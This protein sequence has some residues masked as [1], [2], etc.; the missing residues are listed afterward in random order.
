MKED[1]KDSGRQ[2]SLIIQKCFDEFTKDF[3]KR[4]DLASY[5]T[6]DLKLLESADQFQEILKSK[7]K[8]EEVFNKISISNLGTICS[9]EKIGIEQEK[10]DF[11]QAFKPKR[12]YKV[13]FDED[14]NV[15]TSPLED[16]E[17]WD[18]KKGGLDKSKQ[19]IVINSGNTPMLSLF[20]ASTLEQKELDKCVATEAKILEK[21]LRKV[22]APTEKRQYLVT[23]NESDGDNNMFLIREHNSLEGSALRKYSTP[24]STEQA[25][26][27]YGPLIFAEEG[28]PLPDK[29]IKDNLSKAV[30][31]NPSF[32]SLSANCHTIELIKIMRDSKVGEEVIKESI[33]SMHR[34]DAPNMVKIQTSEENYPGQNSV[35]FQAPND[36][37]AIAF[38]ATLPDKY[39]EQSQ[40]KDSNVLVV[41]TP[42]PNEVWN[43]A[44]RIK[45][46]KTGLTREPLKEELDRE[47]ELTKSL[48]KIKTL[49]EI[50]AL[51]EKNKFRKAFK[52]VIAQKEAKETVESR[53]QNTLKDLGLDG[54]RYTDPNK[55]N[56]P[57]VTGIAT[58]GNEVEGRDPDLLYKM[59]ADTLNQN[60][61]MEGKEEEK[62]INNFNKTGRTNIEAL[63]L[64]MPNTNKEQKEKNWVEKMADKKLSTSRLE[65]T[66]MTNQLSSKPPQSHS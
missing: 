8:F 1:N 62:E 20:G 21:G 15:T 44:K 34:F 26:L 31:F 39:L 3:S 28:S 37:L 51:G 40:A 18:T 32:G 56:R 14:M 58:P 23:I 27:I 43:P 36:K 13:E 6:N 35:I 53:T 16:N 7:E 22:G 63:D 48:P 54:F 25:K 19:F 60:R 5:L 65:Q 52:T 45:D 30:S 61:I 33:E 59:M 24:Y 42:V 38:G 29:T 47:E 50:S 55:H 2:K 17:I 4:D 66:S 11:V 9:E 41:P 12:F 49:R 10:R 64:A 57:H 46:K